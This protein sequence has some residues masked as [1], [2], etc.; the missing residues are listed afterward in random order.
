MAGAGGGG[1]LAEK[2]AIVIAAA[3]DGGRDGSEDISAIPAAEAI[4]PAQSPVAT[5]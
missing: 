1:F 2:A 4:H 5:A 3:H